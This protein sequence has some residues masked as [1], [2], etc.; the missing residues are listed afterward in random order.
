M[1]NLRVDRSAGR[2]SDATV[3]RLPGWTPPR[4]DPTDLIFARQA[5][6]RQELD[7]AERHLRRALDADPESAEVR[8]LMG[9]LHERLGESRAA[10]RCYRIAL[11]TDR[12]N[13]IAGAGLRRCC[14]RF[15]FEFRDEAINPACEDLEH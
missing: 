11:T 13:A 1:T 15:G 2:R 14:E 7:V 12:R 10:Y 3:E 6:D 8:S 5:L 9:V 4:R